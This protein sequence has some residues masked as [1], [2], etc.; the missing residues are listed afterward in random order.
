MIF[1]SPPHNI[2][3]N[4]GMQIKIKE[5]VV[6]KVTNFNYLGLDIQSN[7]GWKSHMLKIISKLPI[8]C[9]VIYRIRSATDVSCLLATI[10]IPCTCN[11]LYELLYYY[12]ARWKCC[13]A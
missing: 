13:I 1:F 5:Y 6:D 8:C 4:M 9:C 11:K 12:L 7:L 2:K 10:M 3:E